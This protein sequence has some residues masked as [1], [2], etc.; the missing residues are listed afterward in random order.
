MESLWE[1]PMSRSTSSVFQPGDVARVPV[2]GAGNETGLNSDQSTR[3]PAISER[4]LLDLSS[5]DQDRDPFVASSLEETYGLRPT[6][7]AQAGGGADAEKDPFAGLLEG[8]SL[9]PSPTS[10]LPRKA[11]PTAKVA[12]V[13]AARR[14]LSGEVTRERSLSR[15]EWG[16]FGAFAAEKQ[17]SEECRRKR[18]QFL[19]QMSSFLES[20]ESQTVKTTTNPELPST[21]PEKADDRFGPEKADD[22]IGPEKADGRIGPEKADD[23]VGPEKADTEGVATLVRPPPPSSLMQVQKPSVAPR[24][25]SSSLM[26]EILLDN[27]D[28]DPSIGSGSRMVQDRVNAPQSRTGSQGA[29][30]RSRLFDDD[31]GIYSADEDK[32]YHVQGATNAPS[33][34]T[35][36]PPHHTLQ[37]PLPQVKCC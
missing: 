18:D 12:S 5:I 21:G 26:R 34:A 25:T 29:Q 13:T 35:V 33:T 14:E 28:Q 23:R 2:N 7:S 31:V 32:D 19:D 22:R 30:P 6:S 9:G 17:K 3:A 8:L 37:Q 27:L 11:T 24:N 1:D 10:P 16:D 15:E 4:N 36:S 20:I